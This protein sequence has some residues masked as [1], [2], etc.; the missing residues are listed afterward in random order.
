MQPA[1]SRDLQTLV[2]ERGPLGYRLAADYIRQAAEELA[3][4]HH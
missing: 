2:S 3:D 1:R 4:Y